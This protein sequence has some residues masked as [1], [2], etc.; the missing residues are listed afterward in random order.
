M[1]THDFGGESAAPTKDDAEL[2]QKLGNAGQ[3]ATSSGVKD[4]GTVYFVPFCLTP[5]HSKTSVYMETNKH[6]NETD[7]TVQ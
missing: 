7:Y 2:A 5:F 3:P 4:K 6:R 1:N